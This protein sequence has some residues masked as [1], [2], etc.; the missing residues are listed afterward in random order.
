MKKT[1]PTLRR[2]QGDVDKA[3]C[4]QRNNQESR[5]PSVLLEEKK[6]KSA[7]LK[8]SKGLDSLTLSTVCSFG[9]PQPLPPELKRFL[10]LGLLKTGFCQVDQAGLEL[11]TSDDPPSSTSQSEPP[12]LARRS[13][14]SQAEGYC[15]RLER[16]AN[17]KRAALCRNKSFV[18]ENEQK[19][20]VWADLAREDPVQDMV[21]VI[22][23]TQKAEAGELN[24]GGGGFESRFVARHQAFSAV[25]LSWLT[26]TST[27]RIQAILLPQ[28]PELECSGVISLQLLPPGLK[29]Y[30]HLSL[31]S[32]WNYRRA[33]PHLVNFCIFNR[34]SFHSVGQAGLE[35][36]TSSD[37]PYSASPII[38]L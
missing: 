16:E 6:D 35:L 10:C 25:V 36:L 30:S 32:G 22:P 12:C 24:P 14:L 37:L 8:C 33:P 31:P 17:N 7:D 19:R 1:A 38:S 5:N 28:P 2:N 34:H 23:A 9:S 11:L 26:A 15:C 13:V 29:R 20:C 3:E 27:S 18:Y 4:V 21:P